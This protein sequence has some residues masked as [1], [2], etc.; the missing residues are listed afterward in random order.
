MR[1]SRYRRV[2]A[3]GRVVTLVCAALSAPVLAADQKA[4]APFEAAAER[5]FLLAQKCAKLSCRTESRELRLKM[6]DGIASFQTELLPYA[7]E[8]A[9]I[10]YPGEA[11]EV[12]FPAD[13]KALEPHFGKVVDRIDNPKVSNG[14]RVA[15]EPRSDSRANFWFDFQQDG[16]GMVLKLKSDLGYY[17]KYHAVMLVPE[18]D[19]LR[20]VDTSSCPILSYGSAIE[21]WPHPIAMIVLS[22]F[23]VVPDNNTVCN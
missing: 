23:H 19:G 13:G 4:Q 9:V 5:A 1:S 10:L 6:S 18:R 3:L 22:D 17:V 2:R 12:D 20:P 11:I 7:D 21:S 14:K 15:T 16:S 8:G